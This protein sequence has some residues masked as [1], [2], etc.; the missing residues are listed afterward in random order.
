MA[1]IIYKE[2]GIPAKKL[3]AEYSDSYIWMDY[4]SIPQLDKANQALAIQSITGYVAISDLFWVLAGPWAHAD[5]GSVRDVRAWGERGWCRCAPL[6]LPGPH[7][8]GNRRPRP[9]V[10]RADAPIAR[11]LLS[12]A[13]GPRASQ[14]GEPRQRALS[15]HQDLHCRS[16]P[17]RCVRVRAVRH[18]GPILV[19]RP[20]ARESGGV[21]H[22][23]SRTRPLMTRAAVLPH[24]SPPSSSRLASGRRS[25][26]GRGRPA[27]VWRLAAL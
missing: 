22:G 2:K 7:E 19:S 17:Y 20:R 21:G 25:R 14:D 9:C 24:P 26:S 12:S 13:R 10:R 27:H 3:R 8:A 6:F 18:R 16:E 1:A 11:R 5:N 15:G 4:L 23:T